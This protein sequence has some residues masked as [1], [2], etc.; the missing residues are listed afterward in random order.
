MTG[1]AA[2]ALPREAAITENGGSVKA[3]THDV[4]SPASWENVVRQTLGDWG[5]IDILVNNAGIHIKRGI[6]E[7]EIDD[8]NKV[9]AVNT[10]GV[11]L[12]MK[13]VIPQMQTQGGGSVVNAAATRW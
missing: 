1:V 8:W 13:S 12:G 10:S 6:L 7:A 2:E 11:W 5:R 3:I 4:A 9:L